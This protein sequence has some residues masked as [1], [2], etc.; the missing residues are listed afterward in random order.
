MRGRW[1]CHLI[2]RWRK[3]KYLKALKTQYL[4]SFLWW[5]MGSYINTLFCQSLNSWLFH[6]R[7]ICILPYI[8]IVTAFSFTIDYV[9]PSM[10]QSELSNTWIKIWW[11]L[12]GCLL[13][14]PA[15]SIK[16]DQRHPRRVW[17]LCTCENN[18]EYSQYMVFLQHSSVKYSYSRESLL[19]APLSRW[20]EKI[21]E[22]NLLSYRLQ[23]YRI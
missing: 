1:N 20:D 6:M 4:I 21:L 23:G 5:A 16:S 8:Y 14:Q 22:I 7:D 18:N 17:A 12:S 11:E 10:D 2:I 19:S 9:L 15:L 13:L 3:C